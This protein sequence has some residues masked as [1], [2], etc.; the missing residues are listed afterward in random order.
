MKV[1][2]FCVLTVACCVHGLLGEWMLYP[3]GSHLGCYAL[4]C[5][6]DNTSLIHDV[7]KDSVRQ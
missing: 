7:R 5:G 4:I 1:F 6:T 3:T 2:Y